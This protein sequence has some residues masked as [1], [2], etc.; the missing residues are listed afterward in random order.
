MVITFVSRV[1]TGQFP[2]HKKIVLFDVICV[3]G[4]RLQKVEIKL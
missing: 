3:T 2:S 4:E 1:R